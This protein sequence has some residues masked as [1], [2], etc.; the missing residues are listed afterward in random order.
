MTLYLL[1]YKNYYNRSAKVH[2]ELINYEDYIVDAV[3][4]FDFNPNDGIWSSVI[5]N[6]QYTNI[7]YLIVYDEDNGEI[8][9][10]WYILESTR[11]RAEQYQLKLLR[12]VIADYRDI[13][14]NSPCFIEKAT[15]NYGNPLLFNSEAMTFNQIKTNETLIRDNTG[16]AWI[17]GYINKDVGSTQITAPTK[18]AYYEE[19]KPYG[20]IGSWHHRHNGTDKTIYKLFNAGLDDE[21]AHRRTRSFGIA[22]QA[23]FVRNNVGFPAFVWH[24]QTG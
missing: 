18:D 24:F 2:S 21:G 11:K 7:D 16:C 10:R 13:V 6:S 23:A 3:Y 14:I 5:V 9:S 1:N 19:F 22:R 15:V 4:D 8:V 20:M 12:D 17:V